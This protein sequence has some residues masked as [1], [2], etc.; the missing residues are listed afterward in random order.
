MFG[1][2]ILRQ[3][4]GTYNMYVKKKTGN[5]YK[6]LVKKS[7]SSGPLGGGGCVRREDSIKINLI[8]IVKQ[9]PSSEDQFLS[10][11]YYQIPWLLYE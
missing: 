6:T 8:E 1:L 3:L 7:N 4:G 2:L 10:L 9:S 5:K 11:S